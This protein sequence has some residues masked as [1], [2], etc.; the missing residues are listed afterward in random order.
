VIE[1]H[2]V[3]G[4][5][6]KQNQMLVDGAL[7]TGPQGSNDAVVPAKDNTYAHVVDLWDE[8]GMPRSFEYV[9]PASAAAS[10]RFARDNYEPMFWNEGM[11][12][13]GYFFDMPFANKQAWVVDPWSDNLHRAPLPPDVRRDRVSWKTKAPQL[14]R[15][16]DAST[17]RWRLSFALSNVS[18]ES[19][20]WLARQATNGDDHCDRR[21][22]RA[23]RLRLRIG[24]G[25]LSG[26]APVRAQCRP[27]KRRLSR[28]D[29]KRRARV[30]L[31]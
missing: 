17:D 12:S 30:Y 5:E 13:V 11:T 18:I 7:L 10:M 23:Y 24:S 28:A 4:G 29:S 25:A 22:S 19:Q 20:A 9:A 26:A 14:K 8:I 16:D 27:P 2:P 1:N 6:A 31:Q 15:G 3:F 21:F